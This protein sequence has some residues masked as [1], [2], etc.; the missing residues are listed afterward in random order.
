[1]GEENFDFSELGDSGGDVAGESQQELAETTNQG[2]VEEAPSSGEARSEPQRPSAISNEEYTP[3]ERALLDRIEQ[4]T[5][6]AYQS[7]SSPQQSAQFEAQTHNFLEG[8]DIDEVLSSGE[9]LN[10]LLLAVYNKGL[11]ESMRIAR[12]GWTGAAPG[13][14]RTHIDQ[15]MTMRELVDNFYAS[16]PDLVNAR[17]TGGAIANEVSQENSELTIEQVFAEAAKRTREVLGLPSVSP[18]AEGEQH[19]RPNLPQRRQPGNRRNGTATLTG[20]AKE[21][22]DLIT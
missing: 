7:Q 22:D 21:I 6:Q 2:M 14:I 5:N 9:N 19:E 15:H 1:M 20:V 4:L 12:E 18:S 16:N 13:M 17:K 11:Q 8:L 10:K 3:R